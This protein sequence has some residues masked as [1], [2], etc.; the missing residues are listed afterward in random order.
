M[1]ERHASMSLTSKTDNTGSNNQKQFNENKKFSKRSINSIIDTASMKSMITL[2]Y[3]MNYSTRLKGGSN[4]LLK[5][6]KAQQPKALEINLFDTKEEL[7]Y[8][9]I[10]LAGKKT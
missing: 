5:N 9:P 3:S 7:S 4:R 6:L 2:G 10:T 1:R 8:R